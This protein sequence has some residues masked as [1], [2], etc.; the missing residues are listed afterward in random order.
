MYHIYFS[1]TRIATM[2]FVLL[3]NFSERELCMFVRTIKKMSGAAIETGTAI[4]QETKVNIQYTANW[5]NPLLL[6][7]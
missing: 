6:Y 7:S 3:H 5:L 4:E 1:T 2:K